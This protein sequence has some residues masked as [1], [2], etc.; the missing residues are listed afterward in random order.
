MERSNRKQADFYDRMYAGDEATVLNPAMKLWRITKVAVQSRKMSRDSSIKQEIKDL[1]RSWIERNS[2]QI[3]LDLG[4]GAGS[5]FSIWLARHSDKYLG[6]DLSNRAIDSYR[7]TLDRSGIGGATV[8]VMDFLKNG[9]PDNHFDLVYASAVLHHFPDT[10]VLCSELVRILKPGGTVIS[11]DPINT[12]EVSRFVR[13]LYRRYQCNREWEWPLTKEDF[14]I[15]GSYFSI[16]EVRGFWGPLSI[17]GILL[18]WIPGFDRPA[19]RL[20]SAGRQYDAENADRVGGDLW[21]CN[22]VAMRLRK[23]RI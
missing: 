10:S 23:K 12:N 17:A 14:E 5:S 16:E 7:Q 6:I 20:H 3:I 15:F 21:R 9:F 13:R 22:A 19:S 1:H 11:Y 4:C 2:N 18:S 8:F